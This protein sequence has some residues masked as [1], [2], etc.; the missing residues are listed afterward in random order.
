M[1]GAQP[2]PAVPSA[3]RPAADSQRVEEEEPRSRKRKEMDERIDMDELESLM[4]EDFF[5]P[6]PA[7]EGQ[8]VQAE[9]SVKEKK[10]A[11]AFVGESSASKKQ[12]VHLEDGGKDWARPTNSS[13]G[14]KQ[15]PV[16]IKTEPVRSP[17]SPAVHRESSKPP[18]VQTADSR[19][20]ILPF[21]DNDDASVIEVAHHFVVFL[22]F[23]AT[24][25]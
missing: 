16:P 15:P 11:P 25:L 18:R 19:P 23:A 17:E 10:Q 5:D 2:L 13:R 4:S 20:N 24:F 9:F 3:A 21:Q 22:P 6:A 12:R 8:P 14:D 1:R 7:E